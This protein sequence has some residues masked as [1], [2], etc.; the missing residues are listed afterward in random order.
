[1]QNDFRGLFSQ[2]GDL[3][4][5]IENLKKTLKH[6]TVRV[7]M[8]ND[9]VVVVVNGVQQ[10]EEL[11]INSKKL[12]WN[13]EEKVAELVSKTINEALLEAQDIAKEEVKKITGGLNIPGLGGLF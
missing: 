5:N 3:K 4:E 6:K 1:M 8:N 9:A 12:P 13:D 10:I 2:L 11:K 7:T